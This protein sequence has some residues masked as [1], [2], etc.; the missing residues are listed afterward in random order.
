MLSTLPVKFR[1]RIPTRKLSAKK[2]KKAYQISPP[3]A[4]R[5]GRRREFV[6]ATSER[7]RSE[8]DNIR[9]SKHHPITA[10]LVRR[11]KK[12]VFRNWRFLK[13][14]FFCAIHKKSFR[15]CYICSGSARK[16][17]VYVK[18]FPP[19]EHK[20]SW[21]RRKE[22][23]MNEIWHVLQK[24]ITIRM[25]KWRTEKGKK[26]ER[27]SK[28]IIYTNH[29]NEKPN[30]ELDSFSITVRDIRRQSFISRVAENASRWNIK[31]LWKCLSAF[32]WMKM[33]RCRR[34]FLRR[35]A[36]NI[37]GIKQFSVFCL[38][39]HQLIRSGAKSETKGEGR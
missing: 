14:E 17:F 30:S 24:L 32:S 28:K 5:G 10:V 25:G 26:S 12:K 34:R 8:R 38:L 19:H 13:I 3:R 21:R 33:V 18:N 22:K 23:F 20:F 16:R 2:D 27:G 37:A 1:P 6:S 15:S 9:H 35:S 29:D 7:S 11:E 36:G 4:R 39:F 31:Y